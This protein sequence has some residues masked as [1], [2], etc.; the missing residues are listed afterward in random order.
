[1]S[2]STEDL[3]RELQTSG[4][5]QGSTAIAPAGEGGVR[6]RA[7]GL[8]RRWGALMLIGAAILVAVVG[9]LPVGTYV[10]YPFSLFVTLL[11][12]T[13]HALVATITGG[14]VRQ[15]EIADN[16]SG[17]TTFSGGIQG[18]IAPAGYLGATLAG[19]GMILTPLRYA[20]W[21]IGTLALVPLAALTVFHPADAFTVVWCVIFASCL[22]VAAWR[23]PAR[24][25]AF[26][27]L[28]LGVETGLNSVRDLSALL[29]ISQSNA[30][31]YTDADAM[32]KALFGPPTF[33]AI[34]WAVLSVVLLATALLKFA[35]RELA[36]SS[37][38][39]SA[40]S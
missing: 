26:L 38:Q 33:W 24:A 6:A 18:L 1:V 13:G 15:I 36:E 5:I 12:E 17:V 22:L 30:H 40:V 27:Q 4:A 16:L 11:H 32:S 20:R 7:A 29:T 21:L 23:L 25:A 37:L 28:F 31:I 34:A 39:H 10:L 19:V 8:R 35:R 2:K 9:S 14:S 3:L